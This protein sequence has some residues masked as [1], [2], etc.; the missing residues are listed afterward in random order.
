MALTSAAVQILL[1]LGAGERHGYAIMRDVEAVTGGEVK[2]GPR[3][4]HDALAAPRRRAHRGPSARLFRALLRLYPASTRRVYGDDMVQLF[5]DQLRN[6][7][8]PA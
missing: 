8:T 2:L 6:A 4:L 1:S 7:R 5:S 3:T